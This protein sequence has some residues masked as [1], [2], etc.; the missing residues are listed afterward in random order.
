MNGMQILDDCSNTH[1]ILGEL[2]AT[3]RLEQVAS[4]I[5]RFLRG[6][7]SRLEKAITECERAA[8]HDQIVQ[9]MLVEF[10]QQKKEWKHQ[11]EEETAR[12]KLAYE[13]LME[14]WKQLEDERRNLMNERETA[15]R[16]NA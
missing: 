4:G 6:Q 9:R 14:G 12:L 13:K 5:E 2:R 16:S 7:F 3:R 10:D 15:G 11:C 1:E 8:E